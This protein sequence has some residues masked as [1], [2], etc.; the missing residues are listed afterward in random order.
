MTAEIESPLKR[1]I[2]AG[3]DLIEQGLAACKRDNPTAGA[4]VM[5]HVAAGA[6]PR[7]T[8]ETHPEQTTVA[9]HLVHDE[10]EPLYVFRFD[11]KRV[12]GERH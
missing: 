12:P 2:E 6:V 7:L 8:I 10:G 11:L 5:A 1:L 3:N 4:A 9:F